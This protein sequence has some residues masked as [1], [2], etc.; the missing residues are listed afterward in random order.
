MV[1]LPGNELLVVKMVR[2][3]EMQ[4]GLGNSVKI[5]DVTT[6]VLEPLDKT[7]ELV[8]TSVVMILAWFNRKLEVVGMFDVELPGDAVTELFLDVI[9]DDIVPY[10]VETA[11]PEVAV[12]S[13][14]SAGGTCIPVLVVVFTL[15]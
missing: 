1:E 14:E 3:S 12:G 9:V 15:N 10:C 8:E 2:E 4:D 11:I 5:G 13:S 6:D 7:A